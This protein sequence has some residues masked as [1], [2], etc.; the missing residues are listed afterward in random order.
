MST[1]AAPR[2]TGAAAAVEA[3]GL[4][5]IAESERHGTPRSLFWPWFAANISVL[6]IPYGAYVLFFG[7]SFWQAVVVGVIG[8]VGSFLLCGLV[9][10]AGKRGSAPTMVLSRAAFGV[11]G[12]RLPAF[13]SWMLLVGWEIVLVVLATQAGSAALQRLGWGDGGTGVKLLIILVVVGISVFAGVFGYQAIMKVQ[14]WITLATAVLTIAYMLLSLDHIDFSRVT[15]LESGS[16]ASTLGA[17]VMLL[18]ALGLGWTNAAAD[19]SRYLPRSA[20]S[21]GVVGWTTFGASVAPLVLFVF[22]LLLAGSE[23]ATMD[24][25]AADP[26][27]TLA[28]LLPTWFMIPFVVVVVL[29]LI[30]GIVLDIYSSGLSLLSMGLRVPRAVAAGIDGVLMTVGAVLV[31]FFAT[32]FL[33]PFQG[34]LITGGVPLAAWLGVFL[35]DMALRRRDYAD[36]D[37]Y[38]PRGRYGAVR[39]GAIGLMLLGTVVGWG[40]VTNTNASWLRWQGYLLGPFGGKEGTWAGAGLGVLVALLVGLVG[41][42]LLSRGAVR[43]QE[44]GARA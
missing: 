33:G 44:S 38:D 8:V 23:Q 41:T 29:G 15:T 22:G 19:Y 42:L 3:N 17:G 43:E 31:T 39:W 10:L 14:T 28:G 25:L 2:R 7:V 11:E 9:S 21:A 32:D 6:A 16:L 34:F 37:L 26:F 27:G 30:G 18:T 24:G 5:V 35:G 4:N 1:E 12:N 20:S 40:L 36:A 13:V